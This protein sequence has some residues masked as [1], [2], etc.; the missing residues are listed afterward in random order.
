MKYRKATVS[1]IN[2]LLTARLDFWRSVKSIKSEE[3]EET[4]LGY[5]QTFLLSSLADGS[6]IQ[7]LALDKNK[8]VSTSGLALYYL[9]PNPNRLS[10]R[11]AYIGNMFTYPEYRK[12]G[13]ATKL[14]ALT[15]DTAKE[16]GCKEIWL[17]STDMGIS[18][19]EKYG[20]KKNKN[21]MNYF[22]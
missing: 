6:F 16:L 1:D 14:L 7:W 12:Q 2:E 20:F 18:I 21:S 5:T 9:P 8:I 10:G 13:I 4:L 17:D 22:A 15:V 3:E 11:V 19:Y